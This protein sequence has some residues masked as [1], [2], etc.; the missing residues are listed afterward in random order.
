MVWYWLDDINDTQLALVSDAARRFHHRLIWIA[1]QAPKYG[2]LVRQVG[3]AQAA[4]RIDELARTS[5]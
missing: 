2:F 4:L 1:S 3:R 5:Q